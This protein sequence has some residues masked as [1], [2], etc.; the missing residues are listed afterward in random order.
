MIDD[1]FAVALAPVRG[2]RQLGALLRRA[3][4]E[5][6]RCSYLTVCGREPTASELSRSLERLSG[7]ASR[8]AF[9]RELLPA[10]VSRHGND[11]WLREALLRQERPGR[12]RWWSAMA[13]KAMNCFRRLRSTATPEF[14]AE[15]IREAI[16]VLDSMSSRA[17][18][19]VMRSRGSLIDPA[20]AR[21]AERVYRELSAAVA[22]RNP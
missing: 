7:G 3:D 4:Q 19:T 11:Q 6:V 21:A 14:Q 22:Q 5:F 1:P 17:G 15:D 18:A 2:R 10:G 20:V 8:T 12:P 16:N 9:L 13:A